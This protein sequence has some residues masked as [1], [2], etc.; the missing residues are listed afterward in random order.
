MEPIHGK[1]TVP[2]SSI[3]LYIIRFESWCTTTQVFPT[4][5]QERS[6]VAWWVINEFVE[7]SSICA[8]HSKYT[9]THYLQKRFPRIPLFFSDRQRTKNP[10]TNSSKCRDFLWVSSNRCEIIVGFLSGFGIHRCDRQK[11]MTNP[12]SKSTHHSKAN[13]PDS[14]THRQKTWD[15]VSKAGMQLSQQWLGPMGSW[16][17]YG[18]RVSDRAPSI[19]FFFDYCPTPG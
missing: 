2:S 12:P 6:S 10:V 14:S 18:S 4:L 17:L 16:S 15:H 19:V 13:R 5:I 1:H 9:N 3:F 11:S 8:I 7:R